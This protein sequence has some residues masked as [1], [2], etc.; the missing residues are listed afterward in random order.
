MQVPMAEFV[1]PPP[2]WIEGGLAWHWRGV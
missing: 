2:Q 1:R